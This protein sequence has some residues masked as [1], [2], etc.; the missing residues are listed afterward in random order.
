[1]SPGLR[2]G[3]GRYSVVWWYYGVAISTRQRPYWHSSFP[4]E[5]TVE[6]DGETSIVK[7]GSGE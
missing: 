2:F 7:Q 6:D 1:M 4:S 3:R 5:K